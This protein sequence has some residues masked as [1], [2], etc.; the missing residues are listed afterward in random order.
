MREEKGVIS[1]SKKGK[2]P[3]QELKNPFL[4]I[5][6]K[7]FSVKKGVKFGQ[8]SNGPPGFPQKEIGDNGPGQEIV[9]LTI[10]NQAKDVEPNAAESIVLGKQRKA[11]KKTA[12]SKR[13]ELDPAQHSMVAIQP[14][15]KR[16]KLNLLSRPTHLIQP[17]QRVHLMNQFLLLIIHLTLV[18]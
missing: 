18:S 9:G 17:R 8:C 11:K 7:V 2:E 4:G 6:L 14:S 3:V 1:G 12:R 10:N 16:P 5:N 13:V 15:R